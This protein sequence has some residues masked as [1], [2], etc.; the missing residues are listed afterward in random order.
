[1]AE[2]DFET[3]SSEILHTGAIFALRRDRVRMPGDTTAV[4]EVV[5]HYGAVGVVAV[6]DDGNI[7]LVYQYRHPFG[8]RLW[9]LPAGLLD[10]SGEPAHLTAARELQEEAGLQ[11]ATW[12][13]L[14]DLDSTPGF[15]DE[16]VRV[17]LA[18]GLSA[19]EQPE[20][21][22]EEA[23]MTVQWFPLEEAARKV[24][25][26]EIVN[27]IAVAGILAAQAVTGGLGQPRPVDSPWID[28]PTAFMAR[29]TAR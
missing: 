27:A 28:K 17:Y 10:A 23:D 1:M 22:H 24:F 20:A 5:E 8:R 4:R 2:H 26:G 21:H 19:A 14:V 11:A 9:E 12:Q 13:V 29:K 18:T 3:I 15:S 6:D 25:S 16:S 7:P